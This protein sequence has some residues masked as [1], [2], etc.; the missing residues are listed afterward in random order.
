MALVPSSTEIVWLYRFWNK[1]NFMREHQPSRLYAG[2]QIT[3]QE[4][5]VIFCVIN[6]HTLINGSN[7]KHEIQKVIRI[8]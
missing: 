8:W 2:A 7:P 3:C 4:C 6:L 1:G 5:N